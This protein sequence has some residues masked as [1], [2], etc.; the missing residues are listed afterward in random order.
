MDKGFESS[1]NADKDS[2]P[3]VA[4]RVAGASLLGGTGDTQVDL[5]RK[6]REDPLVLVQERERAARAA[7]LNNPLHRRRIT[8][9]LRQEQVL[10]LN[11]I[12]KYVNKALWSHFKIGCLLFIY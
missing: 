5:A 3:A 2:I 4:R 12:I 11:S 10:F 1:L 8:E 7:L 6:L 9:L